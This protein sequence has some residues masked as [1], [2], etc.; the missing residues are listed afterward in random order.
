MSARRWHCQNPQD[1]FYIFPAI[2][3]QVGGLSQM[4]DKV[5]N[6]SVHA[7]SND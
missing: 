6:Q 3:P 7:S 2:M 4:A 1:I 5:E